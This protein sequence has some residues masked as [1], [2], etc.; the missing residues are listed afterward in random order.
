MKKSI[1][2]DIDKVFNRFNNRISQ[3]YEFE[4]RDSMQPYHFFKVLLPVPEYNINQTL[5]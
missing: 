2:T 3:N 1:V 4:Y 5:C